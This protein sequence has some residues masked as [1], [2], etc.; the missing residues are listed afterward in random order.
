MS[1]NETPLTRH[2][3]EQVVGRGTLLL[4]YCVVKPRPGASPRYLDGV[5]ILDGEHKIAS[6]AEHVSLS[7]HDVIVVQT[8]TGRAGMY[9]LGQALF[10]RE[11][12]REYFSPRSVSTVAL[13]GRDDDV[14][15]PIAEYFGIKVA[16]VDKDPR[17]QGW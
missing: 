17:L 14:L 16:A 3:W 1:T 15:R 4:E 2:Y 6:K 12:V 13:C 5:I 9:L 10:S 7:R 11:L 8:K